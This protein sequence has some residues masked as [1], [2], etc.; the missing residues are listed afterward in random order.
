MISWETVFLANTIY[1]WVFAISAGVMIYVLLR[2]FS[3][4]L[5]KRIEKYA[6]QPQINTSDLIKD[7]LD[8]TSWLFYVWLAVYTSLRFLNIIPSVMDVIKSATIIFL[9][10]QLGFWLIE[11]IQY[12]LTRRQL[13]VDGKVD[14]KKGPL[15]AVSLISKVVVWTLIS[16][17]VLENI[18]GVHITTLIASLGIGGIAVG[19]AL[20]KILSDLF[21]SLTISID[22]PFVE[23][24]A[25]NIGDFSGTVE[26][27]GLKSTRIRSFTGEQV[28]FSNSDLLA[29][30]IRNYQ[31]MEHRMVVFTIEVTYQTAYQNLQRIPQI[32]QEIVESQDK[33]TFNRAHF[34]S[35]T[36][37]AISFEIAYTIN[38]SDF[39]L[40][41]N[42]QQKI[43]LEI[44]RQFQDNEIYFA[45]PTRTIMLN[46][47]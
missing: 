41:M 28:I 37:S 18:P 29:S 44:F 4:L 14:Y 24:D 6:R 39:T 33:V 21:A 5:R 1:Q 25:I 45:Y 27:I 46:K 12:W 2:S 32:V 3:W 9:L 22:Q 13:G 11:L 23:G 8:H 42:I 26:H 15:A 19:L 35:Y 30:R 20:Q 7:L 43:N 16:V 47:P 17:L 34:K 10:I 40:Y 38:S 31:S 36:P